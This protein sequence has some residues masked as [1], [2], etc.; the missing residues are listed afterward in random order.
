MTGLNAAWIAA[1][2]G[3]EWLSPAFPD[4]VSGFSFDSRRVRPGE[5]FIALPGAVR[6]GHAYIGDACAK[7]ASMALV[8]RRDHYPLPALWTS[9][10]TDALWRMARFARAGFEGTVIGVTGSSGKTSTK[11]LLHH[12]MGSGNVLKTEGNWN[13]QIGLPMTLLRLVHSEPPW[14]AAVV[15]VGI[16]KPGEMEPL[17]QLLSPDLGILT[18]VGSAHL[19]GFGSLEPIAAEKARLLPRNGLSF[20]ASGTLAYPEVAERVERS[21]VVVGPDET[22][23]KAI[24]GTQTDWVGFYCQPRPGGFWV[25]LRSDR[26]GD[27]KFSLRSFSRGMAS[28][29]VLAAC[30]AMEMGTAPR[31]VRERMERWEPSPWRGQ[32][33]KRGK[34]LLFLDCYNANPASMIDGLEAF[35]RMTPSGKRVFVLGSMA[36]LGERSA[37]LH[38]EVGAEIPARSGDRIIFIGKAAG[39][40]ASGFVR[41]GMDGVEVLV[42]QTTAEVGSAL[43]D[44]EACFLK[45]S[46]E[47][48]LEA[49]YQK[50]EMGDGNGL[51]EEG[52]C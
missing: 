32:F 34:K 40:Y 47:Y 20:V 28:N 35:D 26:Y 5:A 15:E 36:E 10:T 21:G 48:G 3:G 46:R 11:D 8:S 13:N 42:F 51:E 49:I 38:E 1:A 33:M 18:S 23:P 50:M 17:A 37:A 52:A 39:D 27:L 45:G 7:G 31:L 6:D 4:L 41:R 2:S 25:F 44:G 12:L 14:R 43:L 22:P 29:A 9:D 30:V 24:P 16:N 19:E